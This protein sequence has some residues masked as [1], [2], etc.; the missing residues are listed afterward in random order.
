MPL[1]NSARWYDVS[2]QR[3]RRN[4]IRSIVFR[5]RPNRL[6]LFASLKFIRVRGTRE[7]LL[8]SKRK[9]G[10]I[11]ISWP[12]Y[13]YTHFLGTSKMLPIPS[14]SPLAR[15]QQHANSVTAHQCMYD[16]VANLSRPVLGTRYLKFCLSSNRTRIRLRCVAFLVAFTSGH[17]LSTTS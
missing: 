14:T 7:F 15:Q 9:P 2:G 1:F 11:P 12:C 13:L 6:L 3:K 8:L 17:L 16:A 10:S 5:L 4:L